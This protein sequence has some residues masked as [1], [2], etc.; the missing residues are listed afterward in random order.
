MN[1]P[2]RA[3]QAERRPLM[4]QR[5]ILSLFA[6]AVLLV[7]ASA[8]RAAAGQTLEDRPAS[9]APAPAAEVDA[10]PA[11]ATPRASEEKGGN[12]FVRALT[13]PFRALARIFGGGKNGA[14]TARKRGGRSKRN[15]A[16]RK[17]ERA[18]L[19][20]ITNGTPAAAESAAAGGEPRARVMPQPPPLVWKPYI[21][22][23]PMDHLSQGRAL[24]E[25]GYFGEA[26]AE[27]SIAAT[28]GPDLVEANNLLGQ[29]HDRMGAHKQAREFYQR[30]LD[31]SPQNPWLLHNLGYS[32]FLDDEYQ[33][34]LKLLKQA[35]RGAPTDARIAHNVAL[36]QFR[37]H[38]FD[39]ALKTYARVEG[40]YEARLRLAD[41]LERAGWE[42]EA[43]RH[44]EAALRLHPNS[45]PALER[46]AD[47]Y[48]RFGRQEQ[49]EALRRTLRNLSHAGGG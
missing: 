24:L 28:V 15:A 36:T 47:L 25:F 13:A 11:A 21:E 14:Q 41:M 40:E 9:V 23:V 32:F 7:G 3:S 31:L 48:Q 17:D 37:L 18:T 30:A 8:P 20:R 19:A 29:A 4:R 27:L 43:V 38:K 42:D 1:F 6:A 34:A 26:I 33:T 39:D 5:H 46:L 49:A 45:A 35:E 16:A 44:Y 12:S 10:A 22:N 2:G